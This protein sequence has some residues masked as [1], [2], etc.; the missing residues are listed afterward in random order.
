MTVV[1]KIDYLIKHLDMPEKAFAKKYRIRKNIISKWR[2]GEALPKPE[3]VAFL[4]EKFGFEINDF[5]D[6]NSSLD[7]HS[8]ASN[9]H[10]VLGKKSQTQ[11]GINE[12]YPPEDNAR[13]EERD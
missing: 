2:T 9:E 1:E 7:N 11:A 12:D 3:N 8:L 4:C 6:S 10:I 5:L 13:Y